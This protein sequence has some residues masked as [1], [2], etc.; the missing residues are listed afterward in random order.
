M[1]ARVPVRCLLEIPRLSV[2]KVSPLVT[3]RPRLTSRLTTRPVQIAQG[4]LMETAPAVGQTKVRRP[5]ATDPGN[6]AL[7]FPRGGGSRRGWSKAVSKCTW[8]N[9]GRGGMRAFPPYPTSFHTHTHTQTEPAAFSCLWAF[10]PQ[11]TDRLLNKTRTRQFTPR[12]LF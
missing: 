12:S 9:D 4:R 7:Y 2:L 5:E 1:G 8:L 10:K 3:P 6:A 11:E